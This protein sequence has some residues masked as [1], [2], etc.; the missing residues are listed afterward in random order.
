MV[1]LP[2]LTIVDK[3]LQYATRKTPMVKA[4][5]VQKRARIGAEDRPIRNSPPTKTPSV[6]TAS[7]D[8]ILDKL[9]LLVNSLMGHITRRSLIPGLAFLLSPALPERRGRRCIHR[10][11]RPVDHHAIRLSRVLERDLALAHVVEHP[12]WLSLERIAVPTATG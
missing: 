11:W 3:A 7:A 12:G 4:R 10:Q 1:S 6:W 8:S 2:A 9:Q 5:L